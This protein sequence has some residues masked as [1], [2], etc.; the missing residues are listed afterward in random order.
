MLVADTAATT[1][2]A[3]ADEPAAATTAMS[4]AGA[5]E[6][7]RNAPGQQHPPP[8]NA[9]SLCTVARALV[10]RSL[11]NAPTDASIQG[12][13]RFVVLPAPPR[14]GRT[15]AR[16]GAKLSFS[17]SEHELS[18]LK[19]VRGGGSPLPPTT[20]GSPLPPMFGGSPLPPTPGAHDSERRTAL[21]PF[22]S[23][24]GS[25]ATDSQ[26]TI[27]KDDLVLEVCDDLLRIKASLDTLTKTHHV[28]PTLAVTQT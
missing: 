28:C 3:G 13:L 26:F 7:G 19:A 15:A 24:Q 16:R 6:P 5:D 12:P 27:G 11:A 9:S 25:G 18:A 21:M 1:T 23:A 14:A 4:T 17:I 10:L 20:G 2:T 22:D 8:S